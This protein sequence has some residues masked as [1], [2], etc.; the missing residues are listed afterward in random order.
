MGRDEYG[1]KAKK[2]GKATKVSGRKAASLPR[3]GH[4][5]ELLWAIEQR[6]AAVGEDGLPEGELSAF[7]ADLEESVDDLEILPNTPVDE[8][9]KI[10]Y[11][12]LLETDPVARVEAAQRALQVCPDCA[13]AYVVLGEEAQSDDEKLRLFQLGVQAGERALGQEKFERDKGR[14]WSVVRTRPYM[15]ARIH[16]AR[17]LEIVGRPDEAMVHYMDMLELD[18]EDHLGARFGLLR[19]FIVTDKD[20]EAW[21]LLKTYD[22]E[23]CAFVYAKPLLRFRQRGDSVI[24]RRELR[25]AIDYNFLVPLF[26]FGA[27]EEDFPKWFPEE[28]LVDMEEAEEYVEEFLPCWAQTPGALEWLAQT[29]TPEFRRLASDT[30]W[31]FAAGTAARRV[32]ITGVR[33]LP[34]GE[35]HRLRMRRSQARVECS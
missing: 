10:I 14:F 27:G 31:L 13:D 6:F 29:A 4:P 22:E 33:D 32:R 26:L 35:G 5:E 9:Q 19:L 25:E 11:P 16:L 34:R 24:A 17:E 15:R 23:S 2:K 18:H 8:A 7:L 30:P 12:Y 21:G 20:R 3:I 28:L 1:E